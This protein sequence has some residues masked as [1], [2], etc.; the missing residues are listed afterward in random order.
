MLH[1]IR[2]GFCPVLVATLAALLAGGCAR[3]PRIER[4]DLTGVA[5]G[6]VVAYDGREEIRIALEDQLVA[7]LTGRGLVAFASHADL[8]DIRDRSPDEVIHAAH[9]RRVAAVLVVREVLPGEAPEEG[10]SAAR[11]TPEPSDLPTYLARVRSAAP[12]TVARRPPAD[13]EV[14]VEVNLFLLQGAQAQRFWSGVA[15]TGAAD[16]SGAGLR[17]LSGQIADA[18]ARAQRELRGG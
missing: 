4:I 13:Q 2:A 18:L 9:A 16:G 6:L 3:E 5:G 11:T 8:P 7:D 12:G 15:I 17:D 1:A 10:G 14:L